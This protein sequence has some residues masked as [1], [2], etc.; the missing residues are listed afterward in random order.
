MTGRR[1]LV[2]G[3]YPPVP[4]APAAATV[5][6]V[7]R[8]WDAGAEVVVASP[9]P[10]AAPFV[11]PLAG[12]AFGRALAK[13]RLVH[14]CNEVVLCLEPGW[15]FAGSARP[16]S[17]A[18]AGLTGVG[19]STRDARRSA[20][21]TARALAEA[22]SG[23]EKAGLVVTGELGVGP[24]VLALLWPSVETVTASSEE[25]ASALRAAGA[26]TPACRTVVR[27][28]VRTVDPFAGSG[29]RPLSDDASNPQSVGP[30]E[31]AELLVVA[32]GRRALGLVARRLLGRHAPAVRLYLR[33]FLRPSTGRPL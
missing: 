1:T 16:R 18:A 25:T 22:L 26:G 9:R 15:P 7:R 6:A 32:R 27:S 29:L 28:V 33:R 31:P 5:A 24:E 12:P 21:H 10:S 13:L 8:A 2:V 17:P 3:S 20:A 30:L 11:V 19:T 14:G 23:F 4:G